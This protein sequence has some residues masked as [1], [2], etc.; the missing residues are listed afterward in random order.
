MNIE[1]L[2][3]LCIEWQK[4]LGLS[5]WRIGLR[6]CSADEL[7]CNDV[8]ATIK[9]SLETE[10][11]LISLLDC[12]DYPDTPFKQDMEVSLVHELLHIPLEYISKPEKGTLQA[13]HLEAFIERTAR[14]LVHLSKGEKE[15]GT[16]NNTRI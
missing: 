8:Q 11:A 15:N 6:I 7:D 9:I 14:L 5:H 4:R 12:A 16:F 2:T 3:T 13:I 1:E 10:C